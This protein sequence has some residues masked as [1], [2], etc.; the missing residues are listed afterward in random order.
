MKTREDL[1]EAE[2]ACLSFYQ[3]DVGI[4]KTQ[5]YEVGKK[6]AESLKPKMW[7]PKGGD[8]YVNY[9][10]EVIGAVSSTTTRLVG[11][12]SETEQGAQR[13]ADLRI[14]REILNARIREENERTG[15]VTDWSNDRQAK[16]EMVYN[17]VKMKWTYEYRVAYEV[18]GIEYC[19]RGSVKIILKELNN[20]LIAGIER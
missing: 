10:G 6:I 15:F 12:E 17:H 20:G 11:I 19:N 2:L 16:Y 4:N 13:I 1:T 7:E 9:I 8:W 3:D 14:E 18:A 5:A